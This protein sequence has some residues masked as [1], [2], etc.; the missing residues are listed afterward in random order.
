MVQKFDCFLT[1]DK[2]GNKIS[3]NAFLSVPST[4][5]SISSQISFLYSNKIVFSVCPCQPISSIGIGFPINMWNAIA[6]ANDFHIFR[7]DLSLQNLKKKNKEQ[8]KPI[9]KRFM[10]HFCRCKIFNFL[11]DIQP[12]LSTSK[13]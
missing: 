11:R 9:Q 6:I 2:L 10:I 8:S 13:L 3:T 12:L 4:K 7:V 5:H 1:L